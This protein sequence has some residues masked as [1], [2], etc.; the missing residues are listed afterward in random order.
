MAKCKFKYD[1]RQLTVRIKKL[2]EHIDKRVDILL[3]FYS[4]QGV[5]YMRINA[6][7]TDRTGAARNG[8]FSQVF[9][10][11][12]L[13]KIVFAHSVEYGIYLETM[14]SGQYQIINPTI[15][16]VGARLMAGLD[17]LLEEVPE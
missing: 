8:L 4:I 13:K 1:D 6:P 5:E 3:D 15:R 7:W 2:P 11:D 10:D 16:V 12:D 9:S 14:E 17:K